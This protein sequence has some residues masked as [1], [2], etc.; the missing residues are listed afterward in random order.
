MHQR[1]RS[2]AVVR[3][4]AYTVT[5]P[6]LTE[7]LARQNGVCAL[8]G[9]RFDDRKIH[10]EG[11]HESRVAPDLPTLDC[12]DP[13][14]PYSVDNVRIVTMQA[15]QARADYGD[16]TL[17]DLCLSV[18]RFAKAQ[19]VDGVE[20]GVRNPASLPPPGREEVPYEVKFE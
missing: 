10:Y 4:K 8:S 6:E 1:V 11:E 15:N 3:K 19:Y 17:L 14:R 13:W 12:I 20:W 7:I 5:L 18:I 2:A 16:D 9:R